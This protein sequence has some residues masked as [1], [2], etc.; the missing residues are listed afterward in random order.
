MVKL[1]FR[2]NEWINWMGYCEKLDKKQSRTSWIFELNLSTPPS[3][4]AAE[5]LERKL[6]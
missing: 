3:N 6:Q 5:D 4:F 1:L 2:Q